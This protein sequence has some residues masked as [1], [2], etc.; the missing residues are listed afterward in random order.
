MRSRHDKEQAILWCLRHQPGIGGIEL[1]RVTGI[2]RS[3]IYI[4][5]GR[6]EEKGMVLREV[7]LS[8]NGQ[9]WRVRYY[10]NV[11]DAPTVGDSRG[12]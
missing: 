5:L 7:K 10:V 1:C 8:P 6:M 2:W 11:G 9:P 3:N 4:Y 12:S